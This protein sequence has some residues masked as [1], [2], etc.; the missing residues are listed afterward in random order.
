M[1]PRA[2][3]LRRRARGVVEPEGAR[4]AQP[5]ERRVSSAARTCH[6]PQGEAILALSAEGSSPLPGAQEGSPLT[7]LVV[8][9]L[10]LDEFE[11]GCCPSC[12]EELAGEE[13]ISRSAGAA[14][15]ASNASSPRTWSSSRSPASPDSPRQPA[16]ARVARALASC[17]R[18]AHIPTGCRSA[19][20]DIRLN[21][22]VF[23][24]IAARLQHRDRFDLYHSVLEVFVPEGRYRDR[25][26]AGVE[27]GRRAWRRR[28]RGMQV[29]RELGTVGNRSTKSGSFTFVA[30]RS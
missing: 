4:R 23:E 20:V 3:L 27:R 5:Q 9:K 17:T 30:K 15:N 18:R 8:E 2:D 11:E 14:P 19:P 26:G 22:L 24:A 12:G 21:G 16:L 7:V 29:V 25:P 6:A 1:P 13:A 28:R 10:D